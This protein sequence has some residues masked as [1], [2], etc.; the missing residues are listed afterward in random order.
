ML[1]VHPP[2]AIA[3]YVLIFSFTSVLFLRK[4]TSNRTTNLTGLFAWVLTFLGLVSGMIWA[5][6]AW[7]G[8]WSWDPKEVLTLAL[9]LAM[10]GT[11]L[12]HFEKHPTVTRWLSLGACILVV[13]T[14]SSSFL[15]AGLHSFLG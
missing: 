13:L 1:F 11:M 3:A 7:D 2:L 12:A 9:F 14:G 10:T 5:Q 6:L 8:Y 4:T 15:V